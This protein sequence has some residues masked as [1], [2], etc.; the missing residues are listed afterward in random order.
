MKS[1]PLFPHLS[2][3]DLQRIFYNATCAINSFNAPHHMCY[4]IYIVLPAETHPQL[5]IIPTHFRTGYVQV[6]NSSW[7]KYIHRKQSENSFLILYQFFLFKSFRHPRIACKIKRFKCMQM[8]I[9]IFTIQLRLNRCDPAEW[10][11][12]KIQFPASPT[13]TVPHGKGKT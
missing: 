9:Y 4:L 3:S 12:N 7:F 1:R 8:Y 11:A 10:I 13:V 6:N 2:S 5:T